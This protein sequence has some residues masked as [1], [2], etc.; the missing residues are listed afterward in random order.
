MLKRFVQALHL[1]KRCKDMGSEPKIETGIIKQSRSVCVCV[2][3][4][5]TGMQ[6]SQFHWE[7]DVFQQWPVAM[8]SSSNRTWFLP[9]SWSV[10]HK[11]QHAFT[12]VTL[13]SQEMGV[14]KMGAQMRPHGHIFIGK[15]NED[16]DSPM[17]LGTGHHIFRHPCGRGN[18]RETWGVDLGL[19]GCPGGG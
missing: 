8:R 19:H 11:I 10:R 6:S 16:D 1:A 7:T 2:K 17:N 13:T 3:T 9:L 4:G 15:M 5:Y 14:E 12:K 18:L